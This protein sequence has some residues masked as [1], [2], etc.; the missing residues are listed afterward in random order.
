[1]SS[2]SRI[3]LKTFL[4]F[5]LVVSGSFL[6]LA[7]GTASAA[8][9][10]GYSYAISDGKATITGYAGPGGAITIPTSL[11]G[12]PVVAIDR[13]SFFA[14]RAL[15]SVTFPEGLLTIGPMAFYNCSGIQTTWIPSS[16]SAIGLSAFAGCSS[17]VAINVSSGNAIYASVEGVLFNKNITAMVQYPAGREGGYSIPEGLV[18]LQDSAFAYCTKLTSV[19]IPGNLTE[20]GSSVFFDCAA[21]NSIDVDA[22]NSVYSSMDGVLFNADRSNLMQYPAGRAGGYAVPSTVI[23]IGKAAFLGSL[24]TYVSIPS[25]VQ[26]IGE[27]AFAYC[28]SLYNANLSYGL[29]TIGDSAFQFCLLDSL[30]IPDGVTE[31]GDSAFE[32][33]VY[34]KNITLGQG[35]RSIGAR[36]FTGCNWLRTVVIPDNVT[37]IGTSAFDLCSGLQSVSIGRNVSVVGDS[38]FANCWSLTSITFLGMVAPT[39]VGSGWL[40]GTSPS[41]R[42]FAPDNSNFPPAGGSF[43]GLRMGNDTDWTSIIV[44]IV[45]MIGLLLI[46]SIGI[47]L[48]WQRKNEGEHL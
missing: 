19:N 45:I 11:G 44:W 34:A 16:V 8:T 48:I 29:E 10:S 15:T 31:I 21:L 32:A 18:S 23:S 7:A 1:M 38:A 40:Q 24:L 25:S 5:V 14:N 6:V 2:S 20:M 28:T 47:Y 26:V 39:E 27:S 35:V 36:A 46:A 13:D 17:L 22:N 43:H 3:H 9:E 41:I 12:Y 4:I 37:S 33:C 30:V 42:G